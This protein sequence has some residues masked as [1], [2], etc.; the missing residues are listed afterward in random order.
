MSPNTKPNSRRSL[1][2]SIVLLIVGAGPAVAGEVSPAAPPRGSLAADVEVDPT[3][4]VLDGHSLHVGLGRGAWRVDLGAFA[5]TV[6][7]ALHGASGLDVAFAGYGAKLQRFRTARRRGAFVGV[8]AALTQLWVSRTDAPMAVR[9][10]QVSIGVQGGY[11]LALP[12]GFYASAWLGVSAAFGADPV[13]LGGERFSPPS[14]N[15]FPA[16]HLGYELR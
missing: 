2:W 3:A 4:F 6:P 10:G 1:P 7:A 16:I 9:Q 8:D 14:I 15:L 11:R 13:V 12:A 5:L